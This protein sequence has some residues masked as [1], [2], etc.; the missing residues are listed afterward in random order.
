MCEL[1]FIIR[2]T[3]ELA[4]LASSSSF[5]WYLSEVLVCVSE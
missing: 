2:C 3:F 5:Q 4:I 1:L